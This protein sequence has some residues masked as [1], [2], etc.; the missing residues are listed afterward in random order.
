MT[1][2]L[3]RR[4]VMRRMT[5]LAL[6][7]SFGAV[8]TTRR[9]TTSAA[10]RA[11][12]AAPFEP[13]QAEL[14]IPPELV[15]TSR[16]RGRETYE[17]VVRRGTAEILPGLETPVYGYDGLFPGPTI[18]ARK[19]RETVVRQR[20]ELDFDVNVHL[21]GGAVPAKHDG[22]PIQLISP[23][24]SFTYRYPNRQDAATLWYHDHA[25]GHTARSIHYGMAAFYLLEDGHER[26]LELPRGEFDVPLMLQDRAF[27]DDGSF[28][29]AQN[30]DTGFLGDTILVNGAVAPRMRVKRRLYRLR[31]LNA[32][33]AREYGL[34]LSRGTLTQIGSDGGLL[35]RPLERQRIDLA[36][37]ERADVV[38]DFRDVPAGSEIV[39][40]NALG[41]GSTAAVMRFDVARGGGREEFRV[42]RRL[43][44]L[45]RLPPPAVDRSFELSLATS[46]SGPRW[47]MGGRGFDMERVD[48]RTRL[49]TSERWQFV[50]PSN[51]VHPM[52][53]HGFLFRVPGFSGWKDTVP[54][55]PGETVTVQPWFAPYPGRYVFHC[56]ALEHGDF[57]MM[58][59]ME[60]EE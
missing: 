50:N 59:Q 45:R 44:R 3:T 8:K 18:R 23:G 54:V 30:I 56:H 1:D 9:D 13:F 34:T 29:Y 60:V 14:P 19:G 40:G 5:S 37:A 39:L 25:H 20:N 10:I 43:R 15:A 52:H 24:G 46:A 57:G 55:R 6:V 53:L 38:V 58:L 33:N 26:E 32:S 27:N 16:R 4:D 22:H 49:G 12:A 35:P 21:H 28:R 47:Q 17:L 51:R 48:I 31:F 11:Q 42:P 36:P 41:E 2:D 7:C